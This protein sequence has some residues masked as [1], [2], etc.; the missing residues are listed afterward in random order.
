MAT[1]ELTHKYFV[2]DNGNYVDICT[3]FNGVRVLKITGFN[4]LGKPVNVYTEQW[5][6]SQQEDFMIATE[7]NGTPKIIRENSKL[8][9]TYIISRKYASGLGAN[10]PYDVQAMNDSLVS[11]LT[12]TDVWLASD[13]VGKQVH[14][15]AD[16]EVQEKTIKLKRGDSSYIIGEISFHALDKPA[17][18][19]TPAIP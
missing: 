11:F 1:T 8:T 12:D 18:F 13:Y 17:A 3:K 2:K 16:G 5:V 19:T 9:L 6:G 14:C 4:T 15:Y 7:V 10:T